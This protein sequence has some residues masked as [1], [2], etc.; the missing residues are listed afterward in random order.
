MK[1]SHVLIV[2]CLACLSSETSLPAAEVFE[3]GESRFS[4]LPGGKE[5]DGIVG[6]LSC[7]TIEWRR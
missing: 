3:V 4:D 5:A 1:P 2:F 6:I 7:A